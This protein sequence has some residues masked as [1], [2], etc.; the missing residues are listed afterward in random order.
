MNTF[1]QRVRVHNK[2]RVGLHEMGHTES[3]YSD[4]LSVL[5]FPWQFEQYTVSLFWILQRD[6]HTRWTLTL[7]SCSICPFQSTCPSRG[8]CSDLEETTCVSLL[9][10]SI[11]SDVSRIRLSVPSQ[12]DIT[13]LLCGDRFTCKT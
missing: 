3:E 12:Q 11:Y 1:F 4:R 2:Y 9:Q 5:S 8:L 6:Y 10:I 13:V 7:K